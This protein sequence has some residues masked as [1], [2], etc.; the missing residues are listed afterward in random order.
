[1]NTAMD[2]S[3]IIK[4]I[5]AYT[6]DRV[7]TNSDLAHMVDTSDEWIQSR[8]GIK[9][10]RIA[11]DNESCSDMATKAAEKA[12]KNAGLTAQ[13][14]DMII[15]ATITPDMPFP[16]TACLVQKQ[17]GISPI[18]CFDVEAACSGFLYILD[19]AS[20]M[21]KTGNYKNALIIGAEKLSSILDWED[22]STCVLFGDGAGAAVLSISDCANVGI[23]GTRLAANGNDAKILYM[24]GG[25]STCP[26][27]VQ[28]IN[29][30]QHYL[31]MLGK[32]VFKSA[33]K[34]MEQ[35][36]IDM[37]REYNLNA[38][39]ISCFIPHQ[40]NIRIIES[41]STRMKIPM[42]RIPVNLDRY[43][44]TSAA[45]IPLALDE[46]LNN[47]KIKNGD[48]VLMIAFG[49]GLTWASTLL[50]WHC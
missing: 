31:K 42:E 45:S 26:A 20:S 27:S 30:R 28:S 49:A 17:L 23:I 32:E 4:G 10:R 1:M 50:K 8:T 40:A 5:G 14:I 6:P 9:E 38:D 19:I 18:P 22:R 43:G 15:V 12:I 16:S 21:L 46:A 39:E 47:N 48:Y 7:L 24:P 37:L 29:D 11:A 34:V 13:D 35:S 33:V 3:I 41:F 36:T 44:N 2:S 25:G